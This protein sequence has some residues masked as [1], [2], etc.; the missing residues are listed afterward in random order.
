MSRKTATSNRGCTNTHGSWQTGVRRTKL[1]EKS[2]GHW[3]RAAVSKTAGHSDLGDL[4]QACDLASLIIHCEEHGRRLRG[5]RLEELQG[6]VQG[7]WGEPGIRPWPWGRGP[8]SP[9]VQQV[10][11]AQFSESSHPLPP[12][13]SRCWS[14]GPGW[15]TKHRASPTLWLGASPST[16]RSHSSPATSSLHGSAQPQSQR[17]GRQATT[18]LRATRLPLQPPEG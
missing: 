1:P 3:H 14:R 17:V 9:Q 11:R 4:T 13:K 18:L 10:C 5:M 7:L 16:S 8:R 15:R 6:F 2:Y 12:S